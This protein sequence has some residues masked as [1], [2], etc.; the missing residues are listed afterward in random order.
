MDPQGRYQKFRPKNVLQGKN[1][2]ADVDFTSF[3]GEKD[4]FS[5]KTTY[6]MGFSTTKPINTTKR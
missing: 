5:I 6:L 1:P 4:H 2:S 3:S